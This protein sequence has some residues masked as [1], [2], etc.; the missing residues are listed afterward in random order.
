[1]KTHYQPGPN[2]EASQDEVD[3]LRQE[4]LRLNRSHA[5]L[6]GELHAANKLLAIEQRTTSRFVARDLEV[7]RLRLDNQHLWQR[8][9]DLMTQLGHARKDML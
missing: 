9:F 7:R 3:Y 4:N 6:S 1:M 2:G 5:R 8:N